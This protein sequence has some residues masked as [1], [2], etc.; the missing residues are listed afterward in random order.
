M[1]GEFVGSISLIMVVF[2]IIT[3]VDVWLEPK[4]PKK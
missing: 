3:I 4:P 2:F 1:M